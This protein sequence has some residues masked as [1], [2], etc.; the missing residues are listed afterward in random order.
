MPSNLRGSMKIFCTTLLNIWFKTYVGYIQKYKTTQYDFEYLEFLEFLFSPSWAQVNISCLHLSEG[1]AHLECGRNIGSR[2]LWTKPFAQAMNTF[3]KEHRSKHASS[4]EHRLKHAWFAKT[5]AKYW[6]VVT[7]N[8]QCTF[9]KKEHQ[10]Y[11]FV[12][13]KMQDEC[14]NGN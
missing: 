2:S 5:I 1:L 9:P 3:S 6:M 12:K 7:L 11:R 13:P 14:S 4:K 8:K 10:R